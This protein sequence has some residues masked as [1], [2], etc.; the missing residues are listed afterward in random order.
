MSIGNNTAK[1]LYLSRTQLRPTAGNSDFVVAPYTGQPLHNWDFPNLYIGGGSE[2]LQTSDTLTLQMTDVDFPF[3]SVVFSPPGSLPSGVANVSQLL[4]TLT[5]RMD[6]DNAGA[7][8]SGTVINATNT[9]VL[10]A[11]P[12]GFYRMLTLVEFTL[13]TGGAAPGAAV[14]CACKIH[15]DGA[16]ADRY[17]NTLSVPNTAGANDRIRLEIPG[18][19]YRYDML[20]LLGTCTFSIASPG[21]ATVGSVI[22]V[23]YYDYDFSRP[24]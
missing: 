10:P 4:T 18:P 1:T 13:G 7:A 14:A 20:S 6:P 16:N 24:D 2:T 3:P 17:V 15:D 5:R 21:V 23:S 19:G 8:T 9:L 11:P 12:V 22:N